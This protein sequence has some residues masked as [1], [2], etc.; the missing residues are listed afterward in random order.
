MGEYTHEKKHFHVVSVTRVFPWA[1]ILYN[2]QRVHTGKKLFS[3]DQCD[4]SFSKRSLLI[5]HQRLHT[6]EKPFTCDQCN[7][8][9]FYKIKSYKTWESS[10]WGK[11]NFIWSVWQE[12]FHEVQSNK[13]IREYTM[14]RIYFHA[15]N[16]IRVF[17]N[18]PSYNYPRKDAA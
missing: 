11:N 10:H 13:N 9:F 3:C 7:K 6:G 12:F 8:S 18:I 14:E 2:Q 17:Q 5:R 15:I 1:I 16:V 4:K